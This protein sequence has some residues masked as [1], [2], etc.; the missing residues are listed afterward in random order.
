MLARIAAINLIGLRIRT[1]GRLEQ[2]GHVLNPHFV[3]LIRTPGFLDGGEALSLLTFYRFRQQ[4]RT[5]ELVVLA[6]S[7]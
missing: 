4:K 2:V 3:D 6:V 1:D 5:L 7:Y